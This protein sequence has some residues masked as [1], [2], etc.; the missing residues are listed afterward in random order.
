MVKLYEVMT[1]YG[2]YCKTFEH[3]RNAIKY[4]C[5]LSGLLDIDMDLI[6]IYPFQVTNEE[7]IYTYIE[8]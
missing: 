4:A 7:Y 6:Q 8:D 2:T 1:F 5:K 3:E